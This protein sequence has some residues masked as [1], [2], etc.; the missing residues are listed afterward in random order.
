MA[1]PR[2]S[3][4]AGAVRGQLARA[5][6]ALSQTSERTEKVIASMPEPGQRS[7]RQRETA[8]AAHDAARAARSHFMDGQA[9]AVYDELT[10]CRGRYL[11]LPELVEAA[12]AAFPGLVPRPEQMAAERARPQVGKEGREIDQ[13]IFLRGVLRSPLAGPHLLNAMLRPT[14]RALGLLPDFSRTGVADLGSV[15]IEREKGAARLTMCAG[16]RL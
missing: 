1:L 2:P 13:G 7:L 4:D 8:A 16:D 5:R 14:P 6:L 12:A 15:R 11:R 9:D 3:Q 10:D